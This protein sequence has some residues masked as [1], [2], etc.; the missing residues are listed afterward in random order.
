MAILAAQAVCGDLGTYIVMQSLTRISRVQGAPT[1]FTVDCYHQHDIHFL[2][3]KP[4]LRP[5]ICISYLQ[6]APPVGFEMW[7]R[8]R[9]AIK[10]SVCKPESAPLGRIKSGTIEIV[11]K[12]TITVCIPAWFTDGH[13]YCACDKKFVRSLSSQL[14]PPVLSNM[15]PPFRQARVIIIGTGD[16]SHIPHTSTKCC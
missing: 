15:P 16:P 10:M 5:K 11:L 13:F 1:S 9:L 2:T 3:P 8:L 6:M 4:S 12:M 14:I 7:S